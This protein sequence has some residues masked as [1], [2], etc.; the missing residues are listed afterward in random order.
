[1]AWLV[2]I[3]LLIFVIGIVAAIALPAYSDYTKR[4]RAAQS[5]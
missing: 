3:P 5:R 1:M 2:A 4:A